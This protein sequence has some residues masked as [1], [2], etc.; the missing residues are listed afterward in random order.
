MTSVAAHPVLVDEDA[1]CGLRER[2]KRETR[3]AIHR[4]ALELASDSGMDAL[5]VDAIAERAGVSPRTFFN[6]FPAKDDALVGADPDD[7]V[8]R[9]RRFVAS[10]PDTESPREVVHALA[11]DRV[12]GLE[13]DRE[14][15]DMRRELTQREPAIGLRVLGVYA[16]ADRAVVEALTER[17]RAA[18]ALSLDDELAVTVETYAALGAFRAAVRAHLSGSH[19]ATFAELVDRAF[20]IL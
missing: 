8:D 2:K 19:A 5:T 6:Y 4:A 11:L 17:A 13:L 16:R 10:R 1:N 12:A 18:R 20:A 15:W 3:R 7:D 9:L 14:L